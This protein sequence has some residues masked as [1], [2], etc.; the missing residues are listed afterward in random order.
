M[1]GFVET[2][3]FGRKRSA[4]KLSTNT[5][6]F[7]NSVSHIETQ[8]WCMRVKRGCSDDISSN[9]SMILFIKQTYM[10]VTYVYI[11]INNLAWQQA[12]P[13]VTLWYHCTSALP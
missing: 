8:S 5:L 4:N 9:V 10:Y 2:F 6:H 7:T 1:R 11:Y 3:N 12:P 13:P